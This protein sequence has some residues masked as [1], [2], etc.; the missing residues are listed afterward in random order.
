MASNTTKKRTIITS[1]IAHIDHGK[2][3]LIDSL[4][5]SQGKISKSI[6]GDLRYMDTRED[7]QKRGIT[8]KLSA[9]SINHKDICYTILDTPGHVDFEFLIE[10]SSVLSDC[11]LIIIDIM[12][13][14]TPRTFALVN[15]IRRD[16]TVLVINKID[17]IETFDEAIDKIDKIILFLNSMCGKHVFSWTSNNIILSSATYCY[18]INYERSKYILKKDNTNIDTVTRF[19]YY[20]EDK[21]KENDVEKIC[22]RFNILKASKKNIL[23]SVMPLSDVIFDSINC[24]YQADTFKTYLFDKSVPLVLKQDLKDNDTLS[25]ISLGILDS[26]K[27]YKK[28][29]LLFVARL[30]QGSLSKGNIL[31]TKDTSYKIDKIYKF[32]I[33]EF[34]EIE[35]A[36]GSS[37]ICIKGDF[38]KNTILSTRSLDY[39]YTEK[40]YPFYRSRL[41]TD[42]NN[43]EEI[44]DILRAI[45]HT[46]QC[47]KIKINKYNQIDVLSSGKVQVE[48]MIEDLKSCNIEVKTGQDQN[49]FCEC[50]KGRADYSY[51]ND[52][53]RILIQIYKNEGN[54]KEYTDE[55]NNRFIIENDEKYLIYSILEIYVLNGPLINEYIR[56][57]TFVVNFTIKKTIDCEITYSQIKSHIKNA[58]AQADPTIAPFFYKLNVSIQEEY[59][60]SIYNTFQKFTCLLESEDYNDI[61][62]FYVLNILIPHFSYDVFIEDIRICTKG[63]AYIL[64][65]EFGYFYDLDFSECLVDIRKKKGLQTD[66]KIINNPEK[67]RT[68]KK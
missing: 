51:E 54:Y 4:V 53:Y 37:L 23:S 27:I 42:K 39:C 33:N 16:H 66:E 3:T 62:S 41:I 50:V 49:L 64:S 14:I 22:K 20:L 52:E 67:Q 24:V 18:G 12:E 59:L 55:F 8:L 17:K 40:I 26:N 60:G 48:K 45:V 32:G 56:D 46:E 15:Y 29:N 57:T 34:I 35:S 30:F 63:T 7:E 38:K 19:I 9:I 11:F 58:Y 10:N 5:A 1:V 68:L 28:D 25:F 13:G 31:F 21:I 43:L 47:L 61:T 44:K 65:S 2:T 6:A 36:D